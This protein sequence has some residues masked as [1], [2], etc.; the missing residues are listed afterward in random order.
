MLAATEVAHWLAFRLIYPNPYERGLVLRQTGHA[1]FSWLP[2]VGG[3]GC[4]LVI[5]A[6]VAHGRDSVARDA[7]QA[8]AA[9]GKAWF[10]VLPPLAFTLQE[11]LERLISSGTP[12]GVVLEP[13]FMLGVAL[14]LPFGL[15]AYLVARLLLGAAERVG[16]TLART[17]LRLPR[18]PLTGAGLYRES[19]FVPR[20]AALAG[21]NAERGPPA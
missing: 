19:V 4:A 6:L 14:T 5:A 1:Y 12:F 20:V 11:H 17:R 21:G 9:D 16:L 2:L 10:A 15:V 3:I 18:L 13:T 8:S 7:P